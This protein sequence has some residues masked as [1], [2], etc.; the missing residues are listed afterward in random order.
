[1]TFGSENIGPN[2]ILAIIDSK[3]I[4]LSIHFL[5]KIKKLLKNGADPNITD[6][7]N[8]SPLMHAAS[9]GHIKTVELL[10][11]HKANP[12]IKDYKGYTAIM[13]PSD[14]ELP[15]ENHLIIIPMLVNAGANLN[16]MNNNGDTA[17]SIAKK[18]NLKN[19]ILKLEE[20]GAKE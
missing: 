18:R 14:S 11:Q 2:V 10:L 8:I 5:P 12:N 13:A 1:M 16:E 19:I 15:S 4:F 9:N 7:G 17:L 20:F 3:K 6:Y